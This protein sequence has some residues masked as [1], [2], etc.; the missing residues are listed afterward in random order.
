M[1]AEWCS[2]MEGYLMKTK[3][4]KPTGFPYVLEQALFAIA[5]NEH[6]IDSW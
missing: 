3:G 2:A 5:N 4:L 6:G 1:P